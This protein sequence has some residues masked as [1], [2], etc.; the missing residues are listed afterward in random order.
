MTGRCRP[1]V[2]TVAME[3]DDEK[4]V[5]P[6]SEVGS[7]RK[8]PD[9][10]DEADEENVQP[11][12]PTLDEIEGTDD[13]ELGLDEDGDG[14]DEEVGVEQ[15]EEDEEEEESE[16]DSDFV[17]HRYDHIT[18]R[19]GE[20]IRHAG[21]EPEPVAPPVRTRSGR[22][23]RPPVRF[24]ASTRIDGCI[25][26]NDYDLAELKMIE[27]GFGDSDDEVADDDEQPEAEPVEEAAAPVVLGGFVQ[28]DP[29]FMALLRDDDYKPSEDSASESEDSSET[30]GSNTSSE[31]SEVSSGELSESGTG[32]D[33]DSDLSSGSA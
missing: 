33:S 11:P 17:D 31:E 6:P 2:T 30:L 8:A 21:R 19:P 32:S 14:D 7:K 23:V 10:R 29:T 5:P 28:A 25:D 15:E 9:T 20:I 16:S 13:S 4:K 1:T 12:G 18:R 26:E 24:V 22:V 3:Q 27:E